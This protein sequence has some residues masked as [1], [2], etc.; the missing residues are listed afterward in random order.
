MRTRALSTTSSRVSFLPLSAAPSSPSTSSSVAKT[1]PLSVDASGPLASRESI[2]SSIFA[3]RYSLAL[4]AGSRSSPIPEAVRRLNRPWIHVS[5][6]S[7]NA[8][9]SSSVRSRPRICRR[10]TSSVKALHT[11]SISTLCVPPFDCSIKRST[12]ASAAD[13]S[14]GAALPTCLG[15]SAAPTNLLMKACLARSGSHRTDL[16]GM[17]DL[18]RFPDA[19]IFPRRLTGPPFSNSRPNVS[20]MSFPPE[21]NARGLPKRYVPSTEGWPIFADTERYHAPA[22]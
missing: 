21:I 5:T 16:G 13:L 4:Y 2:F 22:P 9:A 17:R 18:S 8:G 15:V 1:M 19:P 12:L 20:L 3:L 14:A 11:P 10:A 7:A 6:F